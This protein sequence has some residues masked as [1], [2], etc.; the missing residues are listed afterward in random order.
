[1]PPSR[2]DVPDV[3][4]LL[5]Q[6]G[7]GRSEV[8]EQLFGLVYDEL[9]RLARSHMS[10]ESSHHTWQPTELVHEAFGRLVAQKVSWQNR[11]HFYG[12]AAK[13][14]RRLLVDYARKKRAAKRPTS[15]SAV[16]L[17]DDVASISDTT[18]RILVV[19]QA[20]ERLAA[21]N[22]RQ[23]QIVELKYFAGLGIEEI[24]EVAGVS[25]AT[26]KRDWEEAKRMLFEALGS[27]L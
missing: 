2:P 10:R 22:P 21:V 5:K 1:M 20:L 16:P 11:R 4:V 9:R 27:G 14:M 24:A 25:P 15:A 3:T 26:V 18:E 8:V 12:I 17:E 23:A 13:C 19:D 6:W 7:D